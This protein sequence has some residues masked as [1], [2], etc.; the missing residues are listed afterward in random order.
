MRPNT[1]QGFQELIKPKLTILNNSSWISRE[2]TSREV[3]MIVKMAMV[4]NLHAAVDIAVAMERGM[5]LSLHPTKNPIDV[6]RLL[7]NLFS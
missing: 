5:R 3:S 7:L 4:I 6:E 1:T 2:E